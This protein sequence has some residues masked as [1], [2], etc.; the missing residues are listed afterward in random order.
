MAKLQA[1]VNQNINT[2][3]TTPA[4]SRTEQ[5]GPNSNVMVISHKQYVTTLLKD[6]HE[7]S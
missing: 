3:A 6:L 2:Q 1:M 4:R 5:N 7:E